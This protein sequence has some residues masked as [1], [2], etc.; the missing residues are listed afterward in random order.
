MNEFRYCFFLVII[1]GCQSTNQSAEERAQVSADSAAACVAKG[2]PSRSAAIRQAAAGTQSGAGSTTGMVWI[3]GGQFLMGADEF[4]DARPVHPVTVK[5]FWMDEHEVTNAEFVRFVA[6]HRLQNHRRTSAQP[7]RL[8]GRTDGAVGARLGSI[9][10]TRSENLLRK[11]TPVVGI[12][13]R[14]QL[15]A[16]ERAKKYHQ[17]P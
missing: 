11:P 14:G 9:Y 15:A 4:P 5:G 3:P 10:A 1:A 13:E 8:S 12:R 16:P 17:R 2:M 7:R 6:G